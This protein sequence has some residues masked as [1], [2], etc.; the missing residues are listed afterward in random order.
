[1]KSLQ[2]A[3]CGVRMT[4]SFVSPFDFLKQLFP[5]VGISAFSSKFLLLAEE[6]RERGVMG[7]GEGKELEWDRKMKK[8][9]SA[10]SR[11]AKKN[12]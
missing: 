8:R 3:W 6:E 10:N 7:E 11:R 1:M 4:E 12:I 5:P 9:G 2:R